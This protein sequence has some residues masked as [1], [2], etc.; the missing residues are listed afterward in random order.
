MVSKISL[1]EQLAK[2][3]L[4]P[5]EKWPSGVWDITPFEHGTMSV[6]LFAPKHYDYQTPHEQDELYIVYKGSGELMT[7]NGAIAFAEGD[8]LFVAA[9]DEHRFDNFTD[10]LI[11]WAVFWG[12][13]GGE[14]K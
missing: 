11:L 5:T 2:L 4:P 13:K 10:D 6:V 8:V 14:G 9:G 12:P 1:P 3:P 7:A